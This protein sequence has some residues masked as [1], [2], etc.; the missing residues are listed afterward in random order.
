MGRLLLA[1]VILLLLVCLAAGDSHIFDITNQGGTA[2]SNGFSITGSY[3]YAR[4]GFPAV[5]FGTVRPPAGSRQF[6]YLVLS[7]FSGRR[8]TMPNVKANLDVNES[9]ATDRTTL[10]AG[11][12]KLALV[13]TARLDQGKLASA[14]LTVNGKKVDLHHGQVLLVDFSKEELTWSHRKADLPDNLPEPGNPEAWSALATKL[15]E[16]LR[17]DAAVRDFLK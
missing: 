13:Y 5:T 10:T 8:L 3:T 15:V 2:E 11:G 14:E 12:K 9:E 17:Q 7:K 6:T 16:Q 1:P 4:K